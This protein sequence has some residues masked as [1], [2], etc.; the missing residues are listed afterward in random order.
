MVREALAALPIPKRMR[1]GS[2]R[3]EF[4]RPVQWCVLLFGNIVIPATILGAVSSAVTRGHRFMHP[5]PITLKSPADYEASL[6]QAKVIANFALRRDTI[7]KLVEQEG[8]KLGARPII[9]DELLNEVA[10][11]VEWPVALTG[12]F[13]KAFL[14]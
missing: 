13:D 1:W 3:D 10:A 9:E 5:Q 12:N 11:L 2:S 7:R 8:Q 4:V 14:S 6:Q